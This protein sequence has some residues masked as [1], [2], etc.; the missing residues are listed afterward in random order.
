[1]LDS[2]HLSAI[3][4]SRLVGHLVCSGQALVARLSSYRET[5]E[6]LVQVKHILT[7][8]LEWELEVSKRELGA[9]KSE[10]DAV[11]PVS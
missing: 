6:I 8:A 9:I 2:A 1:M 4:S 5:F 7:E 3:T 10:F 11:R